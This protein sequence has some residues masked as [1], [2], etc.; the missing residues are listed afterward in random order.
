MAHQAYQADGRRV[1]DA[2]LDG[3]LTV[4]PKVDYNSLF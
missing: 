2:T 3:Q 1:L 4:F